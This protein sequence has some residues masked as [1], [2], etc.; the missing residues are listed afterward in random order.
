VVLPA[1]ARNSERALAITRRAL[2]VA[3]CIGVVLAAALALGASAAVRIVYGARYLTCIPPLLIRSRVRLRLGRAALSRMRS[4]L[5]TGLS[6]PRTASLRQRRSPSAGLLSW[7]PSTPALTALL[8][9]RAS[10]TPSHW[11]SPSPSS[12]T[13]RARTFS[14]SFSAAVRLPRALCQGHPHEKIAAVN[15]HL[16]HPVG[17]RHADERPHPRGARSSCGPPSHRP[18]RPSHRGDG[19]HAG[20]RRATRAE[21]CHGPAEIA[22]GA[23]AALNGVR[24][25]GFF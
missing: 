8:S 16:P 3:L 17:G 10:P 2:A 13:R 4:A 19:L 14:R 9:C 6:Q 21:P 23:L 15:R 12:C 22:V 24:T 20:P 25:C 5:S 1:A 7:L 18:G 11:R